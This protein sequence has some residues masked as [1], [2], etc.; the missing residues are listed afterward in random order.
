[1]TVTANDVIGVTGTKLPVS[2]VQSVLDMIDAKIGACLSA[3]P[4]SQ[5]DLI[6]LN[7]A[8]HLVSEMDGSSSITERR[9]PNGGSVK[10]KDQGNETAS[11]PYLKT[12]I[13][14]DTNG[15][16]YGIIQPQGGLDL[17]G[18]AGC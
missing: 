3:Y 6:T 11:T 13:A 4:E 7:L 9:A 12:A 17:T 15:C 5:R 1:M 10:Y 2:I 16:V 14:L 8:C 18:P